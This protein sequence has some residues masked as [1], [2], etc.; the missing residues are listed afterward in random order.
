M[1]DDDIS[2]AFRLMK[3]H[4]NLVSM[5]SSRQCGHCVVN[6]GATFGDNTNPSNFNPLGLGRRQ[7]AHYL[8]TAASSAVSTMTPYLP[9]LNLA[10]LP[11]SA[12]VAAFRPT[13]RDTTNPGILSE[14]GSRKPPPYNMHVD[15]TLYALSL[16][17]I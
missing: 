13:D 10:P 11:T 14:D 12:D 7:L 6:T 9:A 17:H 16:I 5:H 15:D 8:W 4:P 2:G 1:A 3:H